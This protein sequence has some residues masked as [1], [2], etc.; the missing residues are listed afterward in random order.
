[1]TLRHR[2]CALMLLLSLVCFPQIAVAAGGSSERPQ[3]SPRLTTD[4]SVGWRFHYGDA[5]IA[6]KSVG[7]DDSNWETVSVPHTWNRIGEYALTRGAATNNKQGNGWYRLNYAAPPSAKGRRQYLDFAAVAIIADVW[8]NG[9]HVGQHKGGYSRFRFDVTRAW[10]PGAANLIVVKAD[11]SKPAIGSSTEHVMPLAGDF[12]QHGGMYRGVSLIEAN[13]V[14]IDLLDFGG[15]GV[16][17]DSCYN[18]NTECIPDSARLMDGDDPSKTI[19]L[20]VRIRNTTNRRQTVSLRYRAFAPDGHELRTT[21][22]N[23]R[24]EKTRFLDEQYYPSPNS[25]YTVSTGLTLAFDESNVVQWNG[26][27]SPQLHR[28]IV[29]VRSQG[30]LIDS[31][32]QTFGRRNTDFNPNTGFSLNGKPLKLKGVSRHQ[33]RLGKGYALSRADHAEDMAIIKEIGAN[34]VRHAHYQHADEWS[35]EADKAGMIVWAEVPFVTTPSFTGGE[36]SPELFA[37]AEQQTRELIRQNYNHPSIMM[38]S[39]G[40]EVDAAGLFG[41]SKEPVKPLKLLQHI[42]RIAKQEDPTRP[43]IFADCCEDVRSPVAGLEGQVQGEKLAGAADMIGY[44]RYYGWY[45]PEPLNAAEQLAA[46]MDKFHVKHPTL[47][48]SISEYGA[49][50]AISQHSDN[51]TTG[52][53][54]ATGRPQPEEYESWVHEQSWPVIRDRQYIWGS[55]V[56]NMF[57]FASDLRNEGDAVDINTKGLVTMDRKTKKDAF[58]YYKAQWANE[59]VLHITGQRYVDRAYPVMDVRAYSTIDRASLSMNGKPIGE[60]ACKDHICTW[61]NVALG[62]GPNKAEVSVVLGMGGDGGIIAIGRSMSQSATF[63]GPDLA[64][65][66]IHLDAGDIAGR[67]LDRHCKPFDC[68]AGAQDKLPRC[69]SAAIQSPTPSRLDCRAS[70]AMTAGGK[71]TRRFGSDTFVTGGTPAILN[72]GGFGGRGAPKKT[73]TAPD[74]ALYDYWREGEAFSYAVPVPD[75]KWTVTIHMFEPRD[76]STAVMSISVNG[77]PALP[78][79]NVAK[80]AGGSLKGLTRSFPVTVKGGL[81]KLDFSAVGGKAVVA[82]IEVMR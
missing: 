11:N 24:F 13:D 19:T 58:Y 7:F 76:T 60:V 44:N 49:G 78:A 63:N 75:G 54:N 27:T 23:S 64:K 61:P 38:W 33:D 53:V 20:R 14:G 9:V 34:S 31:V 67:V 36:G 40:N 37:N 70:L 48:I 32:T 16:Y 56:W 12:F 4:L 79:F 6:V 41:I 69:G 1:V 45:Y 8:V 25:S 30:K 3:P 26:V 80:V 29:E 47:P 59:L 55:Y 39:V 81:L 5:P 51:P 28:I 15:P 71:G 62:P 50:G 68:L 18:L 72:Q 52:F 66:G 21:A 22:K 42:A 65:D 35:D 73:V 17:V 77:K 82:A 10:K 2:L 74:P 46:Q 43:T 57:D